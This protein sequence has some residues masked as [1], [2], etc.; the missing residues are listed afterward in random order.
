MFF[1]KLIVTF[2]SINFDLFYSLVAYD[3]ARVAG[4]HVREV[5]P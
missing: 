2:F 5:I 4:S 3:L 1:Y